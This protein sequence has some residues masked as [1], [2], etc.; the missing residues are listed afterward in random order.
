[1]ETASP[2][3]ESGFDHSP[4][5]QPQRPIGRFIIGNVTFAHDWRSLQPLF[6]KI[7]V[8]RAE[9]LYHMNGIEYLALCDEFEP[10][11]IGQMPPFYDITHTETDGV[12]SFTFQRKDE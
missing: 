7:V 10:V 6:A 4:T 2:A 12:E 11:D 5:P 9:S 3:L 1:M 8:V